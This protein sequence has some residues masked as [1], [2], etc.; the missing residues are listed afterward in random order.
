MKNLTCAFGSM[1]FKNWDWFPQMPDSQKIDL[2]SDQ[3]S[4]PSLKPVN[5]L[6][7]L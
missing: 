4:L 1:E 5:L 2:S 6:Y 3:E 7:E